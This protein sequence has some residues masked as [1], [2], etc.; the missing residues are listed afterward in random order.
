M[1]L[2]IPGPQAVVSFAER[3]RNAVVEVLDAVPRLTRLLDSVDLML[4]DVS[5]LLERIEA[6]RVAA[7]GV[8]ARVDETRRN[9]DL[10]LGGTAPTLERLQELL[11][12]FQPSLDKLQPVL[13]KLA[14]TTS[15][16]E[17]AALVTLVDRLPVLV[18]EI[19]EQV[20]PMLN[21]MGTVAPDI[22]DLLGVSKELNEMLARL[23]GMKRVKKRVDDE[24]ALRGIH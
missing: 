1:S 16:E 10:L 8:V 2:V 19:D 14:D 18:K 7:D 24:Q 4:A 13:E 6:T 20:I 15:P 23:P 17:V 11:D 22:H 5:A 9:A 3:V 21:S 12:T